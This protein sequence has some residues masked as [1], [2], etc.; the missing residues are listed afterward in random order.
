MSIKKYIVLTAVFAAVMLAGCGDGNVNPD[1][2]ESTESQ[3]K[4]AYDDM[5]FSCGSGVYAEEFEL[6]ITAK[7]DGVIY[8]TTD[9]SDPTTSDTAMEYDGAIAIKDRSGDPNVV[10]AVDP[11]LFCT[12]FSSYSNSQGLTCRME[13]PDDDAVDKCTVIRAALKDSDGEFGGVCTETYFI[14]TTTEHIEGIAESCQAADNDLAV[15]SIT[16]NYED[17]FDSTTGIYVKGD[18][19]DEAFE[20]FK[21]ENGW[22]QADDTRKLDA[23]YSQRGREWEREAHIDFFEMNADGAELVLSQDCGIRVQGNYS[24]SDLQKGFRLYARNEYGDNKFRY[25][26]FGEELKDSS[27]E[28]IDT[29][30]RLVLRAG[31]NCTFTS[32]YNDTFWQTLAT[33]V[34]CA[35]KASRPCVVYI[36][37]EYWGLYVLE[38]D[39]SDDYF[40]SHYGVN[41]DDV[42]VYKGDAETY[43]IGYKLDEGAIPEGEEESYYFQELIDFFDT[44]DSLESEEDYNEFAQLVDVESVM[45]YFAVEVWINNKWDWPGKNWSMWK[46]VNVDSGS[47]YADGKWRFCLYDVEFGG[48]SGAQDAY[49]NTIREDNYEPNGLLDFG[50]DNPAVLCFAYLMTNEGFRTDYCNRLLELSETYFEKE[51]AQ[52]KLTEFEEIY[53]PLFDQFFERYPGTGSKNDALYGGYASSKCIRDFLDKREDNI[54]KMIDWVEQKF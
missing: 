41:K 4:Q 3:V 20:E 52:N 2:E 44:H 18:V 22:F 32:K 36:N 8:Y 9:G 48:V 17:L 38:E 10:S 1:N 11:T 46:T 28:N 14:G 30:K 37:G 51:T 33:G 34:D 43:E 21:K 45:D 53:G 7:K 47:E 31:G 49:T 16:M 42:V 54:Q 12:N 26:V 23:N 27:G 24:R 40:E 19:F 25:D 13:A 15:I 29:F 6:E 35:T 5:S 50:T 39:Y